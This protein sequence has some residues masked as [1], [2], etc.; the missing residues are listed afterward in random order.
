MALGI[1]AR[2]ER[3]CKRTTTGRF[4]FSDL[5]GSFP[6]RPCDFPAVSV[7]MGSVKSYETMLLPLAYCTLNQTPRASTSSGQHGPAGD[8]LRGMAHLKFLDWTCMLAGLE[9]R[10]LLVT[11]ERKTL[12]TAPRSF[13]VNTNKAH[14]GFKIVPWPYLP[15][16]PFP[17]ERP[18]QEDRR[19]LSCRCCT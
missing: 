17:R 18:S 14:W 16:F 11:S 10:D 4:C 12:L 5:C 9:N 15:V 6:F 1:G 2:Q 19:G 8:L 13:S 7:T 3:T